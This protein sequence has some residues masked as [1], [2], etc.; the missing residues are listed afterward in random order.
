MPKPPK[1]NNV[2]VNVGVVVT[3][4][5]QQLE[6]QVFKERESMKTKGAEDW[7]QEEHL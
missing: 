5:S 4:H 2:L 6:Q 7:Q 3:T 1:S